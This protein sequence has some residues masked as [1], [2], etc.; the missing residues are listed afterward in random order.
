MERPD[1][2]CH[3]PMAMA[4][5]DR[6]PVPLRLASQRTTLLLQVWP[7]PRMIGSSF[8]KLCTLQ[9]CSLIDLERHLFLPDLGI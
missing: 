4:M 2:T 7:L 1:L 5:W 3:A 8:L 9:V 6:V